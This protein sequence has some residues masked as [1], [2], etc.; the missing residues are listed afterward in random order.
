MEVKIHYK[1]LCYTPPAWPI[2]VTHIQQDRMSLANVQN[3]CESDKK[4]TVAKKIATFLQFH[5]QESRVGDLW[6]V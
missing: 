1:V 2:T 6:C 3:N 5:N 4:L